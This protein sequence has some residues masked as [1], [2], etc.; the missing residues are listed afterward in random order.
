MGGKEGQCF[1]CFLGKGSRHSMHVP[2]IELLLP[3][4]ESTTD[5][6]ALTN[7]KPSEGHTLKE[8]KL[9]ADSE[10][11]RCRSYLFCHGGKG[12]KGVPMIAQMQAH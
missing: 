9:N 1:Y 2:E 3:Y 8:R 6:N 4:P 10:C 5:D 11:W 12:G 7:V